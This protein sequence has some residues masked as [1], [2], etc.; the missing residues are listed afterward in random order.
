MWIGSLENGRSGEEK[1]VNVRNRCMKT[2]LQNL[3]KE[4]I[5][6]EGI[7]E[8]IKLEDNVYDDIQE[9]Q[10]IRFCHVMRMN[11]QRLPK[12]VTNNEN[13]KRKTQ[14]NLDGGYQQG[15]GIMGF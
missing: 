5:W 3:Q 4:R 1:T 15:D 14:K 12:T 7:K 13:E 2:I 8:M 6:N 11:E 9:K 10:L